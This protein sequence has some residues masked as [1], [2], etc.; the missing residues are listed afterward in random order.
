MLHLFCW[1]SKL[2][3]DIGLEVTAGIDLVVGNPWVVEE[4]NRLDA[5]GK[6]R[7]DIAGPIGS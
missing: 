4:D 5:F 7:L 1:I 2:I 6:G 3:T